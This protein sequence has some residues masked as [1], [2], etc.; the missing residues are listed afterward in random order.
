[1]FLQALK[2]EAL[3]FIIKRAMSLRVSNLESQFFYF[4]CVW[5]STKVSERY[6]KQFR[7]YNVKARFQY[8]FEDWYVKSYHAEF[9]QNPTNGKKD[10]R[11]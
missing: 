1:M 4:F 6:L 2:F 11:V 7:S 3:I 8:H 5:Y 10:M 9:E